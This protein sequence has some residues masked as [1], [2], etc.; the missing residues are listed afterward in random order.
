MLINIK[1]NQ[2]ANLC[3]DSFG[4][5]VQTICNNCTDYR[6]N[7]FSYVIYL[8]V[9]KILNHGMKIYIN[10]YEIFNCIFLFIATKIN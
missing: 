8:T 9:E 10:S 2:L 1:S 6:Y 5:I 3:D 7:V 4:V